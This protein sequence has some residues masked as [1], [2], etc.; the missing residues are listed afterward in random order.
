MANTPVP[1]TDELRQQIIEEY[2]DLIEGYEEEERPKF[3]MDVV[4]RI[5]TEFSL[6]PNAVRIALQRAGVY[7]L[8]KVEPKAVKAEG[9]AA[10]GRVNKESAHKSLV[11]ALNAIGVA[12][13]DEEI[14]SKLTGKAAIYLATC[15]QNGNFS[16]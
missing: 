7:I 3:T 16:S 11:A 5:A 4:H 12:E 15:I 2:V 9:T 6:S 1:M 8:K 10:G 13:V 14:T